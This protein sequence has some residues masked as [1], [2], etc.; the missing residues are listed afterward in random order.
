MLVRATYP[1]FVVASCFCCV[2][3]CLR[4]P[5]SLNIFLTVK[6]SLRTVAAGGVL[7]PS[8]GGV[9]TQ[10]ISSVPRAG[11]LITPLFCPWKLRVRIHQMRVLG[12]ISLAYS[13]F[14]DSSTSTA[15]VNIARLCRMA[16]SSP[17]TP[18]CGTLHGHLR[19]LFSC[20]P[21]GS[22]RERERETL[23]LRLCHQNS[24]GGSLPCGYAA[25]VRPQ[26]T[27]SVMILAAG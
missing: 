27:R 19:C 1:T 13:S 5:V 2:C 10:D 7:P 8:K 23:T 6:T 24:N 18:F 25:A 12:E 11:S 3:C 16:V 20:N 22:E 26:H 14:D 15:A 17:R 21:V 9:N 4:V